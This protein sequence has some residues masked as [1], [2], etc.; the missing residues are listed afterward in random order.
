MAKVYRHFERERLIWD[1]SLPATE[2]YVMLAINTFASGDGTGIF[3]KQQTIAEMTGFSRRTVN[4]AIARLEGEFQVLTQIHQ[5][6]EADGGRRSSKYSVAWGELETLA[7]SKGENTSHG[8]GSIFTW[9]ENEVHNRTVHRNSSKEHT[10]RPQVTEV[11]SMDSE[12]SSGVCESSLEAPQEKPEVDNHPDQASKPIPKAELP[13]K[14]LP[15]LDEITGY[16]KGLGIKPSNALRTAATGLTKD[17]LINACM[18]LEEA[19]A[20]DGIRNRQA[21]LTKAFSDRYEPSEEWLKLKEA[22]HQKAEA[23]ELEQ[24]RKSDELA[25]VRKQISKVRE[26]L[27]ELEAA[28]EIEVHYDSAQWDPRHPGCGYFYNYPGCIARFCEATEVPYTRKQRDEIS[29][30]IRATRESLEKQMAERKATEIKAETSRHEKVEVDPPD[31]VP[32]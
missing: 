3:P 29:A 19:L 15:L 2:R 32:F 25:L 16:L 9:D 6:K 4:K 28:G 17:E 5:Y 8:V 14:R 7:R 30:K 1:S 11:V 13:A 31:W 22:E 12:Q 27:K 21:Y 18:A 24:Q 20:G 10:L 23:E 26:Q